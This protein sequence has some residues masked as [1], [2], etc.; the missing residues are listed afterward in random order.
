MYSL[1]WFQRAEV[2]PVVAMQANTPA[3]RASPPT[4]RATKTLSARHAVCEHVPVHYSEPSARYA[5]GAQ[6]YRS[7]T[8]TKQAKKKAPGNQLPQK[9]YVCM[10]D[11]DSQLIVKDRVRDGQKGGLPAAHDTWEELGKSGARTTR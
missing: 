1:L 11:P 3:A 8:K 9:S 4:T 10:A 6:K 7:L 5:H 2:Q